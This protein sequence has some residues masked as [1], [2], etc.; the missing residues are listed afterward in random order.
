M[1]R[2]EEEG[3][4]EE[5]RRGGVVGQVEERKETERMRMRGHARRDRWSRKRRR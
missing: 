4:E 1:G 2:G 3:R 5:R